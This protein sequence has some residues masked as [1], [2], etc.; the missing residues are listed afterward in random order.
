MSGY[1][2]ACRTMLKG[3]SAARLML[4]NGHPRPGITEQ[5]DEISPSHC[6]SPRRLPGSGNGSIEDG[7]IP[8]EAAPQTDE[9]Y[10]GI[11]DRDRL[12]GLSGP[13]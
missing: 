11:R 8:N 10:S 6:Q 7:I 13:G 5:R 4:R 9:M 2:R 12:T 3:V 1:G